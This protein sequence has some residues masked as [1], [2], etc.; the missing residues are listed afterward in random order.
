MAPAAVVGDDG[1][2]R[3]PW[4]MV[5]PL[6]RDYHD[7]EW[8]VPVSGESAYFERLTLEAFQ[9]GLSWRTILAKRPAFRDLFA[10]FDADVVAAFGPA[11][12]ERLMGEASIVRNRR[13][14][15]AAVV[16]AR[17]VVALRTDG[18]LEEFILGRRPQ[19][20]IE[21]QSVTTTPE[22]H[23]L[24][25]DLK[26]HGFTFVGPTTMHALMEAV[27]LFDP[28]LRDCHRHGATGAYEPSATGAYE[29][30]PGAAG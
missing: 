23:A 29:P 9:S 22:S 24:S 4:A 8:G 30:S 13:K 19:R 15:E 6:D 20:P 26:A 21:P 25:K 3:C 14:I 17:A 12:V 7:T 27:G 18:G 10:G 5:S 28:H 1:R 11:D 2:A 16:N